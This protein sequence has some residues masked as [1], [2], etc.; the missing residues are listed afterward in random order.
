MNVPVTGAVRL[1]VSYRAER[2]LKPGDIEGSSYHLVVVH[3]EYLPIRG[4]LHK[5]RATAPLFQHKLEQYREIEPGVE[6][7][8]PEARPDGIH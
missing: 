3:S 5:L 7:I 8:K 4:A 6:R 1:I 2:L